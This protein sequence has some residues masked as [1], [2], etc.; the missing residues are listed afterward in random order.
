MKPCEYSIMRK[1]DQTEGFI[2]LFSV[3]SKK[4][5][6]LHLFDRVM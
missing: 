1:H 3:I 5:T 2:L 6:V 4:I